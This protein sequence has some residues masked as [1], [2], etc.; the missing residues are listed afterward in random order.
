MKVRYNFMYISMTIFDDTF[1]SGKS[2]LMS[3]LLKMFWNIDE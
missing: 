3:D 1:F 2:N